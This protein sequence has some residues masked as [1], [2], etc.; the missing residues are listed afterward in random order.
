MIRRRSLPAW[1]AIIAMALQALWPLLAQAKP[2]DPLQA[3]AVC[4]AAG[5]V[6]PSGGDVPAEGGPAHEHCRLCV[7][8]SAKPLLAMAD[9][10]ALLQVEAVPAE[11][12]A[13]A[14][15]APQVHRFHPPASPRAPPQ[16]LL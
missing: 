4:S 9:C 2:F 10:T 8:G 3:A 6:A 14:H 13:L 1:L 7:S 11:R 5:T 12:I 16:D 15:V